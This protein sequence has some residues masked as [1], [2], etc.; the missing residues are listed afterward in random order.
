[1]ADDDIDDL[2]LLESAPGTLL[3]IARVSTTVGIKRL[4]QGLGNLVGEL[5]ALSE[6]IQRSES[7]LQGEKFKRRVRKLLRALARACTVYE[8]QSLV[9]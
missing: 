3:A 1:M 9:T 4:H 7:T 8:P 5:A 6:I 2:D